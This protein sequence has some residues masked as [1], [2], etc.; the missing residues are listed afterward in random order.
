MEDV[1]IFKLC[2]YQ[3][4]RFQIYPL[5]DHSL[6]TLMVR[7]LRSFENLKRPKQQFQKPILIGSY[8]AVF[9]I[10]EKEREKNL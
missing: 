2:K 7:V 9:R 5:F 8:R 6:I 3:N 4:D 1:G 10:D